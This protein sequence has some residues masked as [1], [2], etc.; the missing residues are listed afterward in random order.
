MAFV[1]K[2]SNFLLG[3]AEIT[4]PTG[5]WQSI[6]MWFNT[7]I[8]NYGWA[9]IIFTL[10]LKILLLPFDFLNKKTSEKNTRLQAVIQPEIAK[11]QKQYA[12]NKQMINQKTMEIYK[13]HNY[14]VSGS[15]F[16][17]L[18]SMGITLFVF[19]TLLTGL[20]SMASYKVGYQYQ[21]MEKVYIQSVDS[22]GYDD[23]LS[24]QNALYE[25]SYDLAYEN[26]K[27]E[28]MT[29]KGYTEQT[30]LTDADKLAIETFARAKAD[31]DIKDPTAL[32]QMEESAGGKSET[33]LLNEIHEAV[34]AKYNEIKDSWLWVS[35][36]WKPDTPWS[37]S[38][39]SFDEFVTMA[40]I[41]YKAQL[42]EGEAETFNIRLEA[43]KTSDKETYERVTLAIASED[44]ANGYLIIPILAV[45][46]TALSMLATQGK[47]KFK[48][49]K[50]EEIKTA[51]TPAGGGLIMTVVLT[52]LMGYI[53]LTYNS[54]FALYILVGSIFGLA[55]SP[56]LSMAI[57]KVNA[58]QENKKSKDNTAKPS[59]KK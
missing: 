13:K 12:G 47:L 6:I 27:T 10:A 2:I 25:V 37:K 56:L 41:E 18:I 22:T 44:G 4:I 36:V 53:T 9:I 33:T 21:E 16:I 50:K 51:P 49:K 59:Y 48:K 40:G 8:P 1:T 57:R 45:A 11:L 35:N 43:N 46:S 3:A 29:E 15:C 5:V 7:G 58:W 54:V 32:A 20:N 23:Y 39:T 28:L 26:K 30:D 14:N 55:T 52:A 38:A 17:T 34:L 42:G 19:I 31:A 24:T